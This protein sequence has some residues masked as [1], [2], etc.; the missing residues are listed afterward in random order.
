MKNFFK[1]QN[2]LFSIFIVITIVITFVFLIYKLKI[3]TNYI[4]GNSVN[5]YVVINNKEIKV[6]IMDSYDKHVQGLSDKPE[7]DYDT[8]F[9]FEF[10]DKQMRRFWMKNMHFPIDVIWIEDDKVV[11]VNKNCEP[12]G[13]VPDKRYSSVIPVNYVLEVNAGFSDEF[14]IKEGDFV[15]FNY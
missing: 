7:L 10:Q 14:D 2:Y 8:G 1:S 15:E 9:L 3:N 6:E 5:S 11:G 12:E 4:T 13:E